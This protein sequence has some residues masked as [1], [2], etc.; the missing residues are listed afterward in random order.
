VTR[1]IRPILAS[2]VTYAVLFL[3]VFWVIAVFFDSLDV[4]AVG[5][6]TFVVPVAP[7]VLMFRSV[8]DGIDREER[9]VRSHHG[10]CRSCGYDLAGNVSGVCP[11]CGMAPQSR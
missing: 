2:I 6:L 7:A 11:E 5:L 1:L 4:V 8:R 3:M 10:H 9:M